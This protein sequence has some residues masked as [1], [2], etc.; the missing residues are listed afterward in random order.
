M[1]NTDIAS[2]IKEL[3]NIS[4]QTANAFAKEVG[5]SEPLLRKYLNGATPGVDKVVSI[6]QKS[7]VSVEWLATGDGSMYKEEV[8][9]VVSDDFITVPIY[10]AKLSAG[11]GAFNENSNIIDKLTLPKKV[12]PQQFADLN[13]NRFGLLEVSGDSMEPTIYDGDLVLIDF[14][15]NKLQSGLTAFVFGDTAYVKRLAPFFNGVEIMSDN[16]MY[17]PQ[18]LSGKEIEQFKIIGKVVWLVRRRF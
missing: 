2:R 13:H 7:K 1:T 18:Q 14:H 12:L 3:I 5:I 9:S 11:Y 17:K 10:E 8:N 4:G 6:A 15:D 16:S